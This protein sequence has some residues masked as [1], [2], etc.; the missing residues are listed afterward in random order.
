MV[1]GG[2]LTF[3]GDALQFSRMRS[4]PFSRVAMLYPLPLLFSRSPRGA[5]T[6]LS[7]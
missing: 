7:G 4:E 2:F 1:Y 5:A 3:A 6:D